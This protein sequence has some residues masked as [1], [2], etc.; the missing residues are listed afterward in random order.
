MENKK[1]LHCCFG[2]CE[3]PLSQECDGFD[4]SCSGYKSAEQIK[5]Y[6]VIEDLQGDEFGM[7]RDFTVE[8]WREQA[9]EW[10]TMDDNDDVVD[11][12]NKLPSEQVLDYIADFWQIV[13]AEVDDTEDGR[14]FVDYF[15]NG[16][17]I[18]RVYF[19]DLFNAVM[20]YNSK[21]V[22]YKTIKKDVD[23]IGEYIIYYEKKGDKNHKI[24]VRTICENC[25]YWLNTYNSAKL[26]VENRLTN[27]RCNRCKK[28]VLLSDLKEY[29]Y[30]CFEHDED[31]YA[32]ETYESDVKPTEQEIQDLI[33]IVM[34]A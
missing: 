25:G 23:E 28:P 27:R 1:C 32:F 31:L 17:E 10:A 5:R 14:F 3:I 30:T 33:Q 7:Y 9:I 18:T 12:L 22:I 6:R 16:N 21:N 4:L 19:E 34:S 29:Q 20:F 15:D 24:D 13:F 8:Q 2:A 26:Y 11:R